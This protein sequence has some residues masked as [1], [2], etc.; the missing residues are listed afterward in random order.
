MAT[1][2]LMAALVLPG[3]VRGEAQSTASFY[4]THGDCI[5]AAATYSIPG[6]AVF[7]CVK[8]ELG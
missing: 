6:Q 1:W 2:I 8:E 3:G 5:K 7:F 4:P